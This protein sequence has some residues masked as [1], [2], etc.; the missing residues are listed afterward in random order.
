MTVALPKLAYP[1]SVSDPGIAGGAS[2]CEGIKFSIRTMA[3]DYQ[4]GM[5]D[6][7]ILTTLSRLT[8]SQVHS[9]LASCFDHQQEIASAV[10]SLWPSETAVTSFFPKPG[11]HQGVFFH[12]RSSAAIFSSSPKITSASPAR[13]R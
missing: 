13:I 1:H 2:I 8:G 3:G 9:A 6:D 5:A 12:I 10:N 11:S 4:R 7:A